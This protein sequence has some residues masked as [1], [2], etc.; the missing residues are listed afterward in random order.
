M[1]VTFAVAFVALGL[2]VWLVP[3]I[4]VRDPGAIAVAVVV[5]ALL[6]ALVR[7]LILAL[8]TPI[9]PVLIAA[10]TIVFQV[11]AILLLGGLVPGLSVD[12]VGAAFLGSWVYAVAN[13]FL[14]SL[15]SIDRDESYFGALVR[16]LVA[17]RRDVR[18]TTEPGI[19]FVQIDGL[20]HDVL[21]HQIRAGRV[22]TMSRWVRQGSHRLGRWEAL[23][24][25]STPASQAGILFGLV[26]D[27]PG[28][29]WYEKTSRR[30]RVANR[31]GDAADLERRLLARAR[32][33]A[34]EDG[35]RGSVEPLLAPDGASVGN[36]F[37]GGAARSYLTLSTLADPSQGLGSGSAFFSFFFS[38]Y[39]Y[40][41][42]LVLTAAEAVKEVVQAIR[43]QRAGIEPRLDRGGIYPLLRA[44]T[45]VLLRN[46]STAIVIDEMYRGSPRIYVDYVDYDEIAHRAGPERTEA[47]DAIDG[48]D[49][50]LGTLERA[51]TNAPRPYVFVVLSDHGQ[52]L[53]AT[54]RQRYGSS[55]ADL[56]RELAGGGPAIRAAA[57]RADEWGTVN[58]LL[59][60]FTQAEGVGPRLARRALRR[61]IAGGVVSLGPEPPEAVSDEPGAGQPSGTGPGTGPA[62]GPEHPAGPSPEEIVVCASGNLAH[63]Y[64]AGTPGRA[65]LE[66]IRATYP[67]LVEG[68]LTHAGIGLV[69]VRSARGEAVA[70]G[71][72][73]LRRLVDGH[74]E[75]TD[76]TLPYGPSAAEALRSLDRMPNSGDLVVLSAVDPGTDE[77]AAFEELIGSHGGLGGA[78]SAGF[79]LY[80]A[81]W[82]PPQ[83]PLVGAE[84]VGRQ[85][86]RWL[87]ALA[88]VPQPPET[89]GAGSSS[90]SRPAAPCRRSRSFAPSTRE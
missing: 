33:A 56:V 1:V 52:T 36:L 42:S 74:V 17:G 8:A 37:S 44:I 68:L 86:R 90:G 84:A 35:G 64:L 51:A 43:Q 47:L 60:E 57:A 80:P 27:I 32:P 25:T 58:R 12:D 61:R 73:G 38:P 85:L 28:F 81:G 78:Q 76:P 49:G 39:G 63:V 88:E 65:P 71:R 89:D 11:V 54:F 87:A 72:A 18:R 3:G 82:P 66:T 24:P 62:V 50:V 20:A 59:S 45:N 26:D 7:P 41:H 46:L 67:N 19:V 30:L 13:T 23:L 29:R 10:A 4:R 55:L 31:P 21:A 77:V 22:P 15:L 16:Q 53:G 2:T 79:V 70:L 5:L 40:L 9:S 83:E 48:I 14:T 69:L 75:G 6:N 34:D